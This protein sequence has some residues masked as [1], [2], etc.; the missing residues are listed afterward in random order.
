VCGRGERQK[1]FPDLG[2]GVCCVLGNAAQNQLAS[3]NV[4]HSDCER[5]CWPPEQ[6]WCLVR[7]FQKVLFAALV[8]VMDCNVLKPV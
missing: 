8:T 6:Y 1:S 3:R 7:K 5:Q 4:R 2:F